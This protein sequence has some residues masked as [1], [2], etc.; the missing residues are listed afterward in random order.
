[1]H[2]QVGSNIKGRYV[3]SYQLCKELSN[4]SLK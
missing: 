3:D 4:N 1:M 2:R